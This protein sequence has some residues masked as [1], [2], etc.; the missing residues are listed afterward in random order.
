MQVRI[1]SKPSAVLVRMTRCRIKILEEFV[2]EKADGNVIVQEFLPFLIEFLSAEATL[3][4]FL[5][6]FC[7]MR[8]EFL[9]K[10]C[11]LIREVKLL[12]SFFDSMTCCN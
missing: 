8:T 7:L 12:S 4:E 11:L 2:F 10:F 5:K 3:S 1:S 9:K 6:N